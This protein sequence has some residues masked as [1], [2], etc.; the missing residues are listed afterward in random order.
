MTI[1]SRPD[2]DV[3]AS[4]A[5]SGEVGDYPAWLRGFGK[6]FD[7][8]QTDGI[9]TMEQFNYIIKTLNEGF[10]YLAQRGIAEWLDVET[11]PS[12][13]FCQYGG[14]FI[15]PA[16]TPLMWCQARQKTIGAC[17]KQVVL[18]AAV[19]MQYFI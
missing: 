4:A 16:V 7:P 15:K 10:A 9:P 8:G 2:T 19:A 13:A 5:Q 14:N 6:L 12:G 17:L 1:L 11:Y 3:F 18:P